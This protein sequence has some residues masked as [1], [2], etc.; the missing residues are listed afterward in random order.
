MLLIVTI[1]LNRLFFIFVSLYLDRDHL[2]AL[3]LDI[4]FFKTETLLLV[5]SLQYETE[6]KGC[7]TKTCKHDEW[8]GVVV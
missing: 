7:H 1:N 5:D 8:G 6:D 3:C 4:W 2:S